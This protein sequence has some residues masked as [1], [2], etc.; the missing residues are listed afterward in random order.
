MNRM[1]CVYALA[2]GAGLLFGPATANTALAEPL[3]AAGGLQI[4]VAA[5]NSSA[6]TLDVSFKD[7]KVDAV[8]LY[9]DGVLVNRQAVHTREGRGI[10]SFS[11]EGATEGAHQVL[12]KAFDADGNCATATALWKIA[13]QNEDVLGH[14]T[15]VK[16]NAQ[17][18]GVFP[19]QIAIDSSVRN[20]YVTF[21]IDNDFLAFMNYAPYTYNWDTT[22]A[23]NGPHSVGVEI[24]DGESL[25]TVQTLLLAVNV[26]N[27]GGLTKIHNDPKPAP[28]V[29][30]SLG[31]AGDIAA[32]ARSAAQASQPNVRMGLV[33]GSL[34]SRLGVPFAA[35]ALRPGAAPKSGAFGVTRN[36]ARPAPINPVAPD[37]FSGSPL[38]GAAFAPANNGLRAAVPTDTLP[39]A[40]TAAPTIDGVLDANLRPSALRH[41]NAALSVR[42][43]EPTV[44]HI[45]GNVAPVKVGGRVRSVVPGTLG[46]LAA[47]AS[48]FHFDAP[49]LV[50]GDLSRVL[51]RARAVG[52][53]AARPGFALNPTAAQGM[54]RSLRPAMQAA[55]AA[56]H[57]VIAHPGRP[58]PAR[59]RRPRM[60]ADFNDTPVDFDVPTRREA[61]IPMTPFRQIFEYTGGVIEWND[62]AQTVHATNS[63]SDILFTI[64]A[65]SATV[66]QKPVTLERRAT[67]ERGRAIVPVSFLRDAMNVTV[68]YD[69][70]TGHLLIESKPKP[71]A[72]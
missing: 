3:R 13:A 42:S 56:A 47:P 64:G 66:N 32:I 41:P 52:N 7:G 24:M 15:G 67:I 27:P 49:T 11:L 71:A 17:I 57:A 16:Q 48:L 35:P 22:K 33:D 21:K 44:R 29:K 72:K 43:A 59:K 8:E 63:L 25:R 23:D 30:P 10:I 55:K 5:Q 26:N 31:P 45:S 28:A 40:Q 46:E 12:V 70:K 58:T 9:L 14:F 50:A 38:R 1:A 37:F 62:A 34:L 2:T 69:E 39:N 6:A 68:H 53:I 18:Q 60:F 4:A 51:V 36:T 65:S 54:A 19:I 61:G 20:P